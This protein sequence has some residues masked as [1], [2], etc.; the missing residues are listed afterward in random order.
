MNWE[1]AA[2]LLLQLAHL[3]H[4]LPPGQHKSGRF[5]EV[6]AVIEEQKGD[7]FG[8][9]MHGRYPLTNMLMNHTTDTTILT[10]YMALVEGVEVDVPLMFLACATS[11][12]EC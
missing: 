2:G 4:S 6:E 11:L 1:Y 5:L 7:H 8:M 3:V 9:G 12:V 10:S